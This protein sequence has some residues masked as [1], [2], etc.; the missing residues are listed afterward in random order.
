MVE[1]AG[2]GGFR[3]DEL[4]LSLDWLV[5]SGTDGVLKKED[6]A[7][8]RLG[9]RGREDSFALGGELCIEL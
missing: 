4:P 3:N 5:L 1:A 8:L 7:L 6:L 2:F 9:A